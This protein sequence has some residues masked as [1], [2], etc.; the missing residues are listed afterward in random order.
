MGFTFKTKHSF[1][2]ENIRQHRP[3]DMLDLTIW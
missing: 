1:F 2:Q 3:P